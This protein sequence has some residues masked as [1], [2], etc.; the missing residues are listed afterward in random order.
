MQAM[1]VDPH[2]F[3]SSEVID[4]ISQDLIKSTLNFIYKRSRTKKPEKY[5]EN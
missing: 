2:A 5:Y 4:S 3:V 1:T